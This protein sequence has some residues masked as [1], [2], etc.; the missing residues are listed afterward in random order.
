MVT[1]IVKFCNK[2][3]IGFKSNY[4]REVY[5]IFIFYQCETGIFYKISDGIEEFQTVIIKIHRF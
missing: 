3:S 1:Y 2:H 4:T 5:Y